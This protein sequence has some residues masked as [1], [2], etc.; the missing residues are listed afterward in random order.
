[1]E[2]FNLPLPSKDGIRSNT[3]QYIDFDV[4]QLHGL[5]LPVTVM[6]L[7]YNLHA[8]E[9]LKNLFSLWSIDRRKISGTWDEYLSSN[10]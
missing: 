10:K 4:L 5:P 7:F 1:M 9:F 6:I 2:V 8:Y 3:S